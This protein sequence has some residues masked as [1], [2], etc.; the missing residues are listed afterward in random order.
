MRLIPFSDLAQQQKPSLVVVVNSYH[1][2]SKD[3]VEGG[4]ILAGITDSDLL[5]EGKN[6]SCVHGLIGYGEVDSISL[7]NVV[8]RVSERISR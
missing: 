2:F 1:L 7:G 3:S 6:N 5:Q 8:D 4:S